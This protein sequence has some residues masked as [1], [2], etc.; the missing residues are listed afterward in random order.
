MCMFRS[1]F[2]TVFHYSSNLDRCHRPIIVSMNNTD[3][4]MLNNSGSSFDTVPSYDFILRR[5][6]RD[7][8]DEEEAAPFHL[9]DS[10]PETVTGALIVPPTSGSEDSRNTVLSVPDT[11]PSVLNSSIQIPHSVH[12]LPEERESSDPVAEEPQIP[13]ATD[14]LSRNQESTATN[15]I[16]PRRILIALFAVVVIAALSISEALFLR[17]ETG[18]L[19]E[20]VRL[21]QEQAA[22]STAALKAFQEAQTKEVVLDNCWLQANAKMTL[23]ECT[24]EATQSVRT[25]V[26]AMREY[27]EE[28][29]SQMKQTYEEKFKEDVETIERVVQTAPKRIA[30]YV[31]VEYHSWKRWIQEEL[32]PLSKEEQQPEGASHPRSADDHDDTPE[33]FHEKNYQNASLQSISKSILV[34]AAWSATAA[35]LVSALD[36]FWKQQSTPGFKV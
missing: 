32:A 6:D 2:D 14:D 21:L 35:V 22:H 27:M 8:E 23:G 11:V 25:H 9:I 7:D 10:L 19:K 4:T 33:T 20:Q 36:F 31:Q 29:W 5:E 16:S 15:S 3:T 1:S 18:L 12:L 28:T 17:R 26:Q 24:H 30:D 13:T 34:T